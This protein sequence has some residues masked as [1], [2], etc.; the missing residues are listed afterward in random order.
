MTEQQR[1]EQII[2]HRQQQ[3]AAAGAPPPMSEQ[4]ALKITQEQGVVTEEQVIMAAMLGKMI[5]GNLNDLKKQSMDGLKV[6]SVDMSKV[7]PSG[8][9]KAMGRP[10]VQPQFSSPPVVAQPPLMI[11]PV[12]LSQGNNLLPVN[13]PHLVPA[14]NTNIDNSQLEFDFDKKARYEDVVNKLEQIE[15]TLVVFNEKLDKIL[16]ALD[17]KK[18]KKNQTD[19]GTQTG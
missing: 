18:L 1:R 10:L 9:A 15:S 4:D 13:P 2:K 6:G 16:E 14:V 5:N 17:K 7:M 8:I 3:L 11:E 12:A 19:N